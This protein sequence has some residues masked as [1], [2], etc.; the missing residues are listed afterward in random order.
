M[1]IFKRSLEVQEGNLFKH[2]FEES[3]QILVCL[4][5]ESRFFMRHSTE[6]CHL[7]FCTSPQYDFINP[8]EMEVN[9]VIFSLK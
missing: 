3:D 6:I 8:E 1:K 9:H 4:F 5:A 7:V 2:P